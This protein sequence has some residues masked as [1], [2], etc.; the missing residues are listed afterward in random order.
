MEHLRLIRI[1]NNNALIAADGELECV[2]LGKGIGFAAQ[3]DGVIKPDLIFKKYDLS[4]QQ[5]ALQYASLIETIPQ[6]LF[7]L[8][9]KYVN[10]AKERLNRTLL[11]SLV[12]TI[13]DHLSSMVQRAKTLTFI[14]N[15]MLWDIKRL[16]QDEFQ[17]AMELTD[18]F[19]TIYSTIYDEHEAANLAMH[20]I[21]ASLDEWGDVNKINRIIDDIF[22]IV[23]NYF[24]VNFDEGSYAYYRFAVHLRFFAQRVLHG[25][26][27][28]VIDENGMY[29]MISAKYQDAYYCAKEIGNYVKNN[30]SHDLNRDECMYLTGHI[31]Q[32]VDAS[33]KNTGGSV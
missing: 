30:F 22:E 5:E 31:A 33:K 7:Q 28:D 21:N 13:A 16:Y 14:Q 11:P 3:R 20:F 9:E 6:E 2:L 23:R 10:I 29:E 18:E 32:V 8:S 12:L 24:S 17:L 27:L 1:I 26:K 4:S 19:N 15:G 25:Q